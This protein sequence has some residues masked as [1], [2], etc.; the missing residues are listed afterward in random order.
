MQTFVEHLQDGGE[1]ILALIECVF[2]STK[3]DE[4]QSWHSMRL[5]QLLNVLGQGKVPFDPGNDGAVALQDS[6]LQMDF[7][8]PEKLERV[9]LLQRVKVRLAPT[10]LS[11]SI[12]CWRRRNGAVGKL[13]Q[14]AHLGEQLRWGWAIQLQSSIDKS[15]C[16]SAEAK[17]SAP[18]YGR[19][20]D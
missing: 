11:A 14:T 15:L 13:L 9:G 17:H 6:F 4:I 18:E 7:R 12:W 3:N 16:Q 8:N 10:F 1:R 5:S 2:R 20:L 19:V